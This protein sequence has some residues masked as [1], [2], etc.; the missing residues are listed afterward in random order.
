MSPPSAVNSQ[1]REYQHAWKV[2]AKIKHMRFFPA[3]CSAR[4]SFNLMLI[5]PCLHVVIIAFADLKL[6]FSAAASYKQTF[7]TVNCKIN[8]RLVC[9]LG[10]MTFPSKNRRRKN[11]MPKSR[12]CQIR[13]LILLGPYEIRLSL[14]LSV[15]WM[16]LDSKSLLVVYS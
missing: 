15:I 4:F 8:L 5:S 10:V 3:F 12:V 2:E 1:Q 13:D 14:S 9:N 7:H 11:F 6:K 16:F